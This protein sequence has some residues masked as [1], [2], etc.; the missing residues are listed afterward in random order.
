[1]IIRQCWNRFD[2]VA[3]RT[4]PSMGLSLKT[5]ASDGTVMRHAGRRQQQLILVFRP[6]RPRPLMA[7]AKRSVSQSDL[8]AGLWA[9][10]SSRNAIRRADVQPGRYLPTRSLIHGAIPVF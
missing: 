1:M 2:S 10:E 3:H 5:S 4:F 9:T 6:F 8:P 7:V